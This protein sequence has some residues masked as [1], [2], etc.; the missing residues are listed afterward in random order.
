MSQDLKRLLEDR[1]YVVQ[2]EMSPKDEQGVVRCTAEFKLTHKVTLRIGEFQHSDDKQLVG[3]FIK[4][5]DTYRQ[6][7]HRSLPRLINSLDIQDEHSRKRYIVQVMDFVKGKNL[8]EYTKCLAGL[9]PSD[10]IEISTDFLIHLMQ[11]VVYMEKKDIIHRFINPRS[12]MIEDDSHAV[13]IVGFF[14]ARLMDPEVLADSRKPE[15]VNVAPEMLEEDY[16]SRS[17]D[18]WGTGLV[19][20]YLLFGKYPWQ[21]M[22]LEPQTAKQSWRNHIGADLHIPHNDYPP[23]IS[24]FL[25][26]TLCVS[27]ERLSWEEYL[28]ALKQFKPTSQIAIRVQIYHIDALNRCFDASDRFEWLELTQLSMWSLILGLFTCKIARSYEEKIANRY[29]SKPNPLDPLEPDSAYVLRLKDLKTSFSFYSERY[30]KYLEPAAEFDL[31]KTKTAAMEALEKFMSV[32]QLPEYSLLTEQLKMC[33]SVCGV[34][35]A[36]LML[37]EYDG[38]EYDD[39][40]A[41]LELKSKK[42]IVAFNKKLREKKTASSSKK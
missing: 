27:G 5:G 26:R 31:E 19:Y 29:L 21:A 24:A 15:G 14:T 33:S 6:M 40:V 38:E 11:G 30:G 1:S 16:F 12:V 7:K 13:R 34:V 4:I 41:A 42:A 18:I 9:N 17:L 28:Q 10:R 8:E 32:F 25:R 20:Y 22:D 23:Q 35:Y 39:D 2:G 36:S 37:F 3:E